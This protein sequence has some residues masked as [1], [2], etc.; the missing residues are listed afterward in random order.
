MDC[1][2]VEVFWL[3]GGGAGGG[4]RTTRPLPGKE[5]NETKMKKNSSLNSSFFSSP[6][7]E[8]ALESA[9]GFVLAGLPGARLD[10]Q[11]VDVRGHRHGCFS[12]LFSSLLAAWRKEGEKGFFPLSSKRRGVGCRLN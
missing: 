5:R 9:Q 11:A 1:R 6:V 7:P 3:G 10:G 8:L 2:R 12:V 4:V